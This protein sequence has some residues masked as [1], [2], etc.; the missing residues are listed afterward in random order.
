QTERHEFA[1][2]IETETCRQLLRLFFSRERARRLATW[3]PDAARAIHHEPIRKLGVIGG[4]AMGA[5][6]AQVAA[7]KGYDVT[8]K[9]L[10]LDTVRAG[11]Q[12][13]DHLM[14]NYSR[15][16]GHRADEAEQLRKRIQV[17]NQS[18]AFVGSD[19]VVEAVV[20]KMSVKQV[21]LAEAERHLCG[22]SILATNTSALSV[23]EMAT[24]LERPRQFAGL[25]F[26]NPVHRME[27]VEVVRGADTS[28]TT[29]ARLVAFVR[30][31]GK[32]PIVTS[33]SPGFLVNRI[34]FPY[35]GEAVLMVGEGG[36]V[37]EI[38]REIRSFGMP[39]G[40]LELLDTVG[41]DVALHVAETLRP[42]LSGVDDVVEVLTPLVARRQAGLKSKRGFYDY[43]GKHK[44]PR[45]TAELVDFV[46]D[47]PKAVDF[48]DDGLT[49]IQRRL[50]YP[51][52]AE[53]IRCQEESVVASAWAID[54]GMVLGT[55]FAPHRGGPLSMI[56]QIG[57]DTVVTNLEQLRSQFGNRFTPPRTLLTGAEQ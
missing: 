12:R 49:T 7:T 8:V 14:S 57:G 16:K 21:V 25:H 36:D 26:F 42:I 23:S 11:A 18:D 43:R 31:L 15:H 4:G 39:M 9:E 34:L 37:A 13:I 32:T 47:P 27:L 29:V 44:T 40:P 51:M 28:D 33:D 48:A 56:D 1:K 55:G 22:T 52:L 35:L 53:A 54:L 10:D 2:L 3:T 46:A 19:C 24:A 17:T 5:G 41:L 45:T 50:I 20:E 30:S 38:D 6:I